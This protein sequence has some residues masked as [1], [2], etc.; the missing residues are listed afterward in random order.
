MTWEKIM[1]FPAVENL[2]QA[3]FLPQKM[4]WAEIPDTSL[5]QGG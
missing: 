2:P 4:L 5:H 3:I 1:T